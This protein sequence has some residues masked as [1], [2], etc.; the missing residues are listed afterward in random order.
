MTEEAPGH[1]GTPARRPYAAAL[2]TPT[3][4][5][6]AYADVHAATSHGTS[7]GTYNNAP[8]P[9]ANATPTSPHAA[10]ADGHATTSQ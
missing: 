6:A 4:P 1:G 10:Y 8:A 2:A 5:H 3:S 9:I 7:P